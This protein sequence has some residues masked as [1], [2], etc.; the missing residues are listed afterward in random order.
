MGA[1]QYR[2]SIRALL[3]FATMPIFRNSSYIIFGFI[4]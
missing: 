1:I 2:H 4:T 3:S